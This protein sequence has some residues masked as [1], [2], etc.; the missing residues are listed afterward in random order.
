MINLEFSVAVTQVSHILYILHELSTLIPC[1]SFQL[2]E[3]S[4]ALGFRLR[5]GKNQL[6]EAVC[7]PVDAQS[8]T[9]FGR[10]TA[11]LWLERLQLHEPELAKL[12]V[13]TSKS[14]QV[15]RQEDFEAELGVLWSDVGS[16]RSEIDYSS[17]QRILKK[18]F[19]T[20]GLR[21]SATSIQSECVPPA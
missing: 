9:T 16:D 10:L 2:T 4:R 13:S 5:V 6:K 18:F 15:R 20:R 8:M 17:A 12:G 19:M 11:G 21:E 7:I 1:N 14:E 3:S